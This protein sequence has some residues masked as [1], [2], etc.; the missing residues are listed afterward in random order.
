MNLKTELVIAGA[1]I[2][3]ALYVAKKAS[4]AL[5]NPDV[6]LDAG[7]A[8]SSGMVTLTGNVAGGVILGIGDAVGIPRTNMTECQRA[9]AEGR[10]WDASFACPAS[11]FIQSLW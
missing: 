9:L 2:V 6:G 8:V 4:A 3:A 10:T 1:L 7:A 11:T 5:S